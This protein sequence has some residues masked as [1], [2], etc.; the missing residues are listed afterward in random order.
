MFDEMSL[1]VFTKEMEGTS[2]TS[3]FEADLADI[4][5]PKVLEECFPSFYPTIV[6][7]M[8]PDTPNKMLDEATLGPQ[9]SEAQLFDECPSKYMQKEVYHC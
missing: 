7:E 9:H 6:I 1:R 5:S 4:Q 2:S 8:Q 3:S